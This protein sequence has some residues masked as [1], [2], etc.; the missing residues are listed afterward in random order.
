MLYEV[1]TSFAADAAQV[2]EAL[3][4][5]AAATAALRPA[6]PATAR[7]PELALAATA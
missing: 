1:I 7:R 3:R 6:R 4:R 5:I 2:A